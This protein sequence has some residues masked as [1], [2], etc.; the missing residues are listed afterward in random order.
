M[1]ALHLLVMHQNE[2][3]L[4]SQ[5]QMDVDMTVQTLQLMV[6]YEKEQDLMS[7]TRVKTDAIAVTSCCWT[8]TEVCF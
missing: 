2:E 1:H 5:V 6:L 8:I 3:T 7:E 4:I